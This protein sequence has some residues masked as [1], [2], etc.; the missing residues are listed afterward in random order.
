MALIFTLNSIDTDTKDT[1]ECS[2][3]INRMEDAIELFK[4]LLSANGFHMDNKLLV[5][6]NE[7]REDDD[8]DE[9]IDADVPNRFI[10][11]V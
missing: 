3:N 4:V 10:P 5:I 2:K 8:M 7:L 1:V 11:G 6:I 9:A